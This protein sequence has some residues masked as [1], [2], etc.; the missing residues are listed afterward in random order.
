LSESLRMYVL[1]DL[2]PENK[3]KVWFDYMEKFDTNL[4]L[5]LKDV[6]TCSYETMK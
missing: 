1:F 6:E 2:L 4:C 3:N 5:D